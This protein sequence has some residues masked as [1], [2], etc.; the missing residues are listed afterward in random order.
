[1]YIG[2]PASLSQGVCI[3]GPVYKIFGSLPTDPMHSVHKGIMS[4]AMSLISD[5]MSPSQKYRLD[6]L[7]QT[8]HKM[9]HQ[10]AC[11]GF[12]QTNFS[13]GVTNLANM[14][15]SKG[16]GLVFLFICLSQ[17]EVGWRLLN[18]ALIPKD[19]KLTFLRSWK[20]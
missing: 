9:H 5:C 12:P 18:D 6:Q 16:C 19:T 8:F 20:L 10:S 11:K 15:A 14:T 7:V 2:V 17:F 13:N 1:M 4:R 3:D